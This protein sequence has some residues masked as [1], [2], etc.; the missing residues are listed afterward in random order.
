[1]STMISKEEA[2]KNIATN[3]ERFMKKRGLNQNQ[4]ARLTGEKQPVIS[5]LLDGKHMPAG[6]RLARLAEALDV[7]MDMLV[8][9]PPLQA[10][11]HSFQNISENLSHAS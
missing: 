1:M 8:A 4:L 3:V 5:A 11:T 9:P 7:T 10:P 2:L 6:D